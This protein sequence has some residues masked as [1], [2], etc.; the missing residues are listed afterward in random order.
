[1]GQPLHYISSNRVRFHQELHLRPRRIGHHRFLYVETGHGEFRISGEEFQVQPGWLGLLSPGLRENRYSTREPVS[2]LFVEF[3]SSERLTDWR[4]VEFQEQDPQRAALIA[5]LKTI[6]VQRGDPD[7]CLLAAAVRLMFPEVEQ[8]VGPPLDERLQKVKR[9]I[10]AAPDRNHRISELAETAGLS[11]P[12]L[13]R[14]FRTQ[15]GMSPKQ[16]LRRARMEFAQRLMQQEG[17]R[18]GEAAHLL[19]FASVFQF[20]AQ[21]R[22]VLGHPPSEDRGAG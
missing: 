20:S 1:M 14:L 11:E 15:L 22:Q 9:L 3:Q 4:A 17:L 5:L 19:G 12:H 8:D 13:R 2:Y 16:Y 21:Y 10:E 7:G 6:H 18:V